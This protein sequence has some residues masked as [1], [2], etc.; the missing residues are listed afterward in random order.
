MTR[1]EPTKLSEKIRL[2]MLTALTCGVSSRINE[3]ELTFVGRQPIDTE[4]SWQLKA[5]AGLTCLSVL[6]FIPRMI[7]TEEL[8]NV[9]R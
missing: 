3:C 4:R 8:M 1:G 5:K 6:F 2:G 7:E 9:I